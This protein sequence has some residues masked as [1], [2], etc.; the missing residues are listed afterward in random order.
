MKIKRRKWEEEGCDCDS[1]SASFYKDLVFTRG[2]ADH[3]KAM[4]CKK[5]QKDVNCQE[6]QVSAISCKV[7]Q[8]DTGEHNPKLTDEQY[9]QKCGDGQQC[10]CPHNKRSF[11]KR[12]GN[13]GLKHLPRDRTG[14]WS[15]FCE[16]YE[17]NGHSEGQF[18]HVLS[19]AGATCDKAMGEKLWGK[20]CSNLGNGK[21]ML[22]GDAVSASVRKG[23]GKKSNLRV[24]KAPKQHQVPQSTNNGFGEHMA[25]AVYHGAKKIDNIAGKFADAV[26][27]LEIKVVRRL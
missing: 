15:E 25:K 11:H 22:S 27:P 16:H 10:C 17:R 12:L 19:K 3:C 14:D 18:W 2:K 8:T 4:L 24:A 21:K 6:V 26:G 23:P 7:G 5:L 9:K 1:T 13:A 20:L